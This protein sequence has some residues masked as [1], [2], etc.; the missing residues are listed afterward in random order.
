M[1]QNFST[2]GFSLLQK[3]T[4]ENSDFCWISGIAGQMSGDGSASAQ[5]LAAMEELTRKKR[6]IEYSGCVCKISNESLSRKI[7][8]FRHDVRSRYSRLFVHKK[9]E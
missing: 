6:G 2:S 9:D 4:I 1:D 5:A 7:E 3:R 8:V